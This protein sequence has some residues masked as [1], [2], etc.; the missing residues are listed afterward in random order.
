MPI[1]NDLR[2][3]LKMNGPIIGSKVWYVY[4]VRC[5]DDTLYTGATIDVGHRVEVHNS[6][7]GAKYTKT[8]RPVKLVWSKEAGTKSQAM[9]EEYAI[10]HRM[11]KSEKEKLIAGTLLK[12]GQ[13]IIDWS[14]EIKSF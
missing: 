7:K 6:G 5:A 4:M 10:K 14:Y 1:W 3:H 11:I 2:N 8:R 12:P 13:S 9:R